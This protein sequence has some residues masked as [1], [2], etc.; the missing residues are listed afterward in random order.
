MRFDSW[1]DF[2]A[3]Q[4]AQ[5]YFRE[6]R[7]FVEAERRGWWTP[8]TPAATATKDGPPIAVYP[9]PADVFRFTETALDQVKVVILG[10]DPYC[11]PGQACGLAFSVRKGVRLPPSL[12]N[13]F[14]ELR[15]DVGPAAAFRPQSSWW[16]SSGDLSPWTKQGVLLLNTALTVCAGQPGSHAAEWQP[17]TDAAIRTVISS[18]S[19]RPHF[20][21]WGSHARRTFDRATAWRLRRLSDLQDRG[22]PTGIIVVKCVDNDVT[23]THSAHPSPNSA[24]RGFFDSRPFTRANVALRIKNGPDC[25]VDW[26]LP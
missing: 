25:W 20:V 11:G 16:S 7:R 3:A 26:R 5:P 4:A 22:Q 9:P 18:A 10:Q 17:F 15:A 14:T 19:C 8:T 1:R 13:V 24:D 12:R 6:I 23:Y 21:L 2:L